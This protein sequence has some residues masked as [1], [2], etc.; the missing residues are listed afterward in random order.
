MGTYRCK[1][2]GFKGPSALVNRH[3]LL[4]HKRDAQPTCKVCGDTAEVWA[5]SSHKTAYCNAHANRY[6]LCRWCNH[7]RSIGFGSGTT[8]CLCGRSGFLREGAIGE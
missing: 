3:I 7:P 4:T 8:A 2:C 5:T 1:L 6:G